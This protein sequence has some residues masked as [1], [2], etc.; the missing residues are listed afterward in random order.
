M[1]RL[2]DELSALEKFFN[3]NPNINCEIN[4]F[5]VSADQK[6]KEIPFLKA[7]QQHEFYRKYSHGKLKWRLKDGDEYDLRFT[8]SVNML[9]AAEINKDWKGI[10][11]FDS[12]PD[13]S[14]MTLFKPV[15]LFSDD[16]CSG[17]YE[18]DPEHS[19]HLYSYEGDP[20]NL[21][22]SIDN[23]LLMALSFKGFY[24]WQY[25]VQ[26]FINGNEN[27]VVLDY[28]NLGNTMKGLSSVDELK[29]HYDQLKI[30]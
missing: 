7:D 6:L 1:E 29:S 2:K 13:N 30:S 21:K 11:Y 27:E 12:T 22:L 26:Y 17:V 4:E 18:N 28:K 14:M 8:G 25:L 16:A 19:M 24:F 3:E 15:D 5:S 23:Y 20:L 9:P 10:V